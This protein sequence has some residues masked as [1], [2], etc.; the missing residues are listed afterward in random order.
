MHRDEVNVAVDLFSVMNLPLSLIQAI[1]ATSQALS[2]GYSLIIQLAPVAKHGDY[3]ATSESFF[4]EI[5]GF[6][7]S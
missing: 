3:E 6:I 1:T 2:L 5:V 7:R 4:R